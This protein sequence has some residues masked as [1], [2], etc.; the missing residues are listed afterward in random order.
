[1]GI[2]IHFYWIAEKFTLHGDNIKLNEENNIATFIETGSEPWKKYNTVY[3]NNTI[4][5]NNKNV[6]K[7][8][9]TLKI[10]NGA[11][12]DGQPLTI[13]IDSSPLISQMI[14]S[15]FGEKGKNKDDF[16]GVSVNGWWF[17]QNGCN[18]V[19][20][21]KALENGHTLILIL[22]VTNRALLCEA[23]GKLHNIAEDIVMDG[24]EYNLAVSMCH[25]KDSVQL[26]KFQKERK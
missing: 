11:Q 19:Y 7:Y 24:K 22:D 26:M 12:H 2:I 4:N 6:I 15:D 13:G 1:M 3:G 16:Y 5:L 20:D 14:N 9:W 21:M 23:Y 17:T 18:R 10:L 8:K 25:N